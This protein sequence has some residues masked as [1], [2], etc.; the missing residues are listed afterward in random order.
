MGGVGLLSVLIT[1]LVP[2]SDFGD[3]GLVYLLLFITG[4]VQ[5]Y[6]E[7]RHLQALPSGEGGAEV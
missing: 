3:A 7:K 4:R 2:P 6:W 5:A 1:Y